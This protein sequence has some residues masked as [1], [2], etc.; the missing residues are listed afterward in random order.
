MNTFDRVRDA[1]LV[2]LAKGARPL[3]GE[4]KA[5]AMELQELRST[6]AG[7]APGGAV[8]WY[9]VDPAPPG[10]TNLFRDWY[11]DVSAGWVREQKAATRF[12]VREWAD[13]LAKSLGTIEVR[14]G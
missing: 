3:S 2:L 1:A 12:Y 7:R 10:A 11:L 9:L 8:T 4:S 14:E 13:T 6:A 5:M